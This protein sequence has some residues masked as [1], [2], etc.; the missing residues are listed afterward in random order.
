MYKFAFFLFLIGILPTAA[1]D[2]LESWYRLM[3][4]HTAAVIAVKNTQELL[5]QWDAGTF[6]KFMQDAAVQRWLAPMNKNGDAPWDDVFK[7]RYGSSM[8]DVLKECPGALACFVVAE[9]LAAFQDSS[10]CVNLCEATGKQQELEARKQAEAALE[11]KRNAK[12]RLEALDLSGVRA[13]IVTADL[14][15]DACYTAWAFVG[16]V[17]ISANSRKLLERMIAAL[18]NGTANSASA[19]AQ[20]HLTRIRQH[21]RDGGDVM[22]YFNGVKLLE[23]GQKALAESEAKK[24]NESKVAAS[25]GFNLNPAQ[26]MAALGVH[27]LQ[28]VAFTL[29]MR[30]Q[31][32][33][34]D[35][36]LL[37]TPQ[38]TGVLSLLRA[39]AT[40]VSLPSFIPADAQQGAVTRHDLGRIY[41]SL[42]G[43]INRLGP[44]AMLV[45]MQIPQ[46]E[47]QLGFKI[48]SDLFGS[49]ADEI[50]TIQAGESEEAGQVFACK[51]KDHEKLGHALAGLKRFISAGFGTFE[52]SEHQGYE[53]STLKFSDA[54][55]T[56]SQMALCDTGTHLLIS[57]GAPQTLHKVLSRMRD[58]GAGSSIWE[59]SQVRRMLALTPENYSGVSVADVGGMLHT[60]AAAAAKKNTASK[61]TASNDA[62]KILEAQ[63][64]PP[65]EVFQRYFGHMLGTQFSHADAIQFSYLSLPPQE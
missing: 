31:Q 25:L 51:I 18:Q 39:S 10:T 50:A 14:E 38:P 24:K 58:P 59:D 19:V 52:K 13:Q 23:L 12:L 41:D 8:K 53:I 65:R 61:K 16:D 4:E 15:K 49:L 44:V 2:R 48:R 40:G 42:M 60:V 63:A 54:T 21:T 9:D 27:E 33:R 35:L 56:A 17:M 29:E 64:L 3:P 1:A 30:Q 57:I 36:T 43:I 47:Q 11:M 46:F 6:S 22:V 37:H 5:T 45:T 7:K 55:S 26:I 62:D 34:A 28:A 32:T 20:E